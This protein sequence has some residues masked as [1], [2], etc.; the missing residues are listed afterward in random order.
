MGSI[1]ASLLGYNIPNAQAWP[2]PAFKASVATFAL[3]SPLLDSTNSFATY[4]TYWGLTWFNVSNQANLAWTTTLA[5]SASISCTPTY[6]L[7][8]LQFL[9]LVFQI[10]EC[11]ASTPYYMISQDLCYD[12]CPSFYY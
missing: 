10:K 6:P 11:D 9:A 7:L 3:S 4:N 12:I 8:N 2:F 5:P 1:Y